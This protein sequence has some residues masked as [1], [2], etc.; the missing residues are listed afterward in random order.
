MSRIG[1]RTTIANRRVHNQIVQ[2]TITIVSRIFK[3]KDNKGKGCIVEAVAC[4][5]IPLCVFKCF[6]PTSVSMFSWLLEKLKMTKL[7]NQLLEL[8]KSSP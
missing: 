6:L 2:G 5:G 4:L 3:S 8:K 7:A 1:Y